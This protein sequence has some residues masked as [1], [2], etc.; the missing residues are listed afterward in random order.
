MVLPFNPQ[1]EWKSI[2][3]SAISDL[4]DLVDFDKLSILF[5]AGVAPYAPTTKSENTVT[6]DSFFA[7]FFDTL[8]PCICRKRNTR[9]GML[10]TQHSEI[11]S[12]H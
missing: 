8:S 7:V 12:K 3:C 9:R 2:D 1:A 5:M 11:S 6:D 10:H 4:G